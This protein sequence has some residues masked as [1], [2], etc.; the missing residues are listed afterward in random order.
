LLE[1]FPL[2]GTPINKINYDWL[3]QLQEFFLSTRTRNLRDGKNSISQSTAS[4]YYSKI[5]AALNIALKQDLIS[6]NPANKIKGIRPIQSQ[7]V[8]LTKEELQGL[9]RTDCPDAEIKRAFLFSCYT[10]LRLSDIRL[11]DW[12]QIHKN[13]LEFRQKKTAEPEYMPLNEI[14]MKLLNNGKTPQ[15]MGPVFSLPNDGT[16]WTN[17]Q[18]WSAAASLTKHISFHTAR[19]TFATLALTETKNI[20][21]VS[22]LLGHSDI[23]HTQIYAK[24]IDSEKRTAV[25]SLPTIEFS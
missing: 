6:S 9:A 1:K 3:S 23:K 16:L 13:Q 10:G 2:S 7:R 14:A 12:N 25:E 8:Y 15:R 18:I 21:L 17:L 5:K 24:I 19:H 4:T 20:Y 11:L 22:K